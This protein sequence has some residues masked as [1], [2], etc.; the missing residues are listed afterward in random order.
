MAIAESTLVS[1]YVLAATGFDQ[2]LAIQTA[3]TL[4]ALRFG[5]IGVIG[6]SLCLSAVCIYFYPLTQPLAALGCEGPHPSIY[7]ECSL[8]RQALS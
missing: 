2:K 4:F 6:L 8:F 1:G 7:S 3:D 5:Y